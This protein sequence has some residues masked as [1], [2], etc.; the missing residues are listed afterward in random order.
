[1]QII[2]LYPV[3]KNDLRKASKESSVDRINYLFYN[4]HKNYYIITNIFTASF[5][6]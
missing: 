1:M 5:E 3:E 6:K 4:S 2:R